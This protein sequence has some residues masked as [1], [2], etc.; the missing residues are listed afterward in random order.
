MSYLFDPANWEWV[1][2][3]NN[4]RF[5]LEGFFINVQIAVVSMALALALGL[6]LALLSLSRVAP[7][8]LGAKVWV[9]V[10]RNL[11]LIFLILYL[12][13]TLPEGVRQFWVDNAPGFVPEALRSQL[14]LAGVLGLVLYNSAVLAEIMR[15]GVLSLDR[16][17]RE[18]A[19]AL[20]LSYSQQMREVILP[21]GLRRMVPA[22]VSQLV[23]LTKDTTLVSIIAIQEAV[24]SGRIL[25]QTA[26]NPFV[27]GDVN[28]PILQ[29][30]I[31]VGVL[32]I[33]FN[34]ALS[35]LSRRLETRES[36]R[37]ATRAPSPVEQPAPA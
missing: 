18:A 34:L 10:F 23:T 36:R 32:F 7:V 13:L 3:G 33:A 20:G 16:G 14:V 35:R 21:Q 17:Q 24:R 30:M 9:D 15:A 27:G 1:V 19:A 29:V 12:A 26:G 31:F 8:R 28:A 22:T 6:T 37:T 11:P 2:T 25:S 5:L 4:A